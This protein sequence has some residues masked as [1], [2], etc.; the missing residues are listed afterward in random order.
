MEQQ[1]VC[2]IWLF[3]QLRLD[4]TYTLI[5]KDKPNYMNYGNLFNFQL[6]FTTTFEEKYNQLFAISL[7]PNG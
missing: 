5:F 3:D 6:H 4:H 7:H 2:F 1:A